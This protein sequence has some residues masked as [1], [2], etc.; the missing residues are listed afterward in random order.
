VIPPPP[1]RGLLLS[2][3]PWTQRQRRTR[4]RRAT[5]QKAEQNTRMLRHTAQY[6]SRLCA[7]SLS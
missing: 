6:S 3:N 4:R 7:L 5:A 2:K 1:S